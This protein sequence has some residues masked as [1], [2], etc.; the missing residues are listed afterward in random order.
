MWCA[1]LWQGRWGMDRCSRIRS[2]QGTV[3]RLRMGQV[4]N[5]LSCQGEMRSARAR[6]ALGWVGPSR[7]VTMGQVRRDKL[8]HGVAV[9]AGMRRGL[10]SRD[11]VALGAR[12]L[13]RW[14]MVGSLGSEEF[15][16]Q[17][18][19]RIGKVRCDRSGAQGAVGSDVIR[20]GTVGRSG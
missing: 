18:M 17:G 6:Q 8:G 2:V 1:E 9:K 19:A 20:L 5:D 11:M 12:G 7:S 15:D 13:G 14:D 10:L 16:C 4:M 3:R